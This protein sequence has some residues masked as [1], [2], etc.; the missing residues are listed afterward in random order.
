L[1]QVAS[2]TAQN[3]LAKEKKENNKKATSLSELITER[4]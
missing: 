3:E 4:D 1:Y 2:E